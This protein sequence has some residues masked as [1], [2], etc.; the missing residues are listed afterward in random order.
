M[1]ASPGHTV[2]VL[3]TI[4]HD[5]NSRDESLLIA[6]ICVTLLRPSVNLAIPSQLHT[7]I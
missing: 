3:D 7:P 2:T 4:N 5:C 1:H 6:D